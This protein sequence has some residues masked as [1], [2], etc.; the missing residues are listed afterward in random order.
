MTHAQK[1]ASR[2]RWFLLIL[3]LLC[4]LGGI[5]WL[6]GFLFEFSAGLGGRHSCYGLFRAIIVSHQRPGILRLSFACFYLFSVFLYEPVV[7][8]TA[9]SYM[10][11]QVRVDGAACEAVSYSRRFCDYAFIGGVAIFYFGFIQRGFF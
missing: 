11:S 3:W 7:F 5:V 1:I 6:I 9:T 2:L 4:L 10:E 8:S